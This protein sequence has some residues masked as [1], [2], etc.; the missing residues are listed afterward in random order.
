MPEC[1]L[2]VSLFAFESQTDTIEVSSKYF[3]KDDR[4]PTGMINASYE[5]IKKTPGTEDDVIRYF[6]NSPGV[7]IGIDMANELKV[8]G[9]AS[10]ENQVIV[11]NIELP[12]PNHFGPQGTNNGLLSYINVQVINEA[13]FYTGG[14][15]VLFGDK[16][17]SIMDIKLKPGSNIKRTE[18]RRSILK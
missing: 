16:L 11:D 14:F 9:G 2:N 6:E 3:K 17:S 15:P 10:N 12:N 18:S 1:V 7:S 13:N 4:A 5:E 8:R